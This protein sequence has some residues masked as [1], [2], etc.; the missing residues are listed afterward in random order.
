MLYVIYY[1]PNIY[2][3]TGSLYRLT[4]VIQFLLLLTLASNNHKSNLF[5]YEFVLM[6]LNYNTMLNSWYTTL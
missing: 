5:F 3:V 6:V 1:I 4:I 2:L